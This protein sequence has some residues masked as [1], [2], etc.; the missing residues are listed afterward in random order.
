MHSSM[1]SKIEKAHRYA[2]ERERFDVQSMVVTV[3]GDNDD[4]TVHYDGD[5]WSCDCDYFQMQRTCA[6]TMALEV[7]LEGMIPHHNRTAVA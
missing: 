2:T 3:H 5:R 4:H 7:M 1:I 6:H